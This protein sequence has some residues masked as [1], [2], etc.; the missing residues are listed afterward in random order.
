MVVKNGAFVKMRW[1]LQKTKRSMMR[2]ICGSQFRNRKRSMDLMV[3]LGSNKTIDQVAMAS[4]VR[5][6]G[7]VLRR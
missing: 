5:W 1:I 3:M 6:Y 2:V 4:S 7:N